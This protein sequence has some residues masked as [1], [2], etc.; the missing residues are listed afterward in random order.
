MK[1]NKTI[2]T[3]LFAFTAGLCNAQAALCSGGSEA[4]SNGSISYSIGLPFYEVSSGGGTIT[5]GV[6]HAY[7]II[8]LKTSV[9]DVGLAVDIS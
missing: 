2:L 5:A 3:I 8:E 6:Q 7:K 4:S 9:S 1:V